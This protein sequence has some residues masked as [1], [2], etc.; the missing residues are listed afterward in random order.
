MTFIFSKQFI[1]FSF[2][3]TAFERQEFLTKIK[4]NG[5]THKKT[6]QLHCRKLFGGFLTNIFAT[7]KNTLMF[8]EF[9]IATCLLTYP[10]VH[11]FIS[12]YTCVVDDEFEK[13]RTF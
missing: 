7:H 10:L 8:H 5:I 2:N 4:T 11:N 9:L 12:I 6:R 3:F 13:I 1:R